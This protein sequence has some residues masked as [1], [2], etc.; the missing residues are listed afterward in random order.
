MA[1]AECGTRNEF[2]NAECGMRNAELWSATPHS[3]LHIPH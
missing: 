1:I 2:G 3:A